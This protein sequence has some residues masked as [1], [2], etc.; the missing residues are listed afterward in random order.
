MLNPFA[1]REKNQRI[2][3]SR[4]GSG[5][6]GGGSNKG[7]GSGSGGGDNGGGAGQSPYPFA[8]VLIHFI[9]K[10]IYP[11]NKTRPYTRQ[12]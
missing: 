12:H 9:L 2:L 5:D 4:G 3:V 10:L 11:E 1:D 7:R 8:T 6:G